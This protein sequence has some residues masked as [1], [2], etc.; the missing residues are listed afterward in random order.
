M[1]KCAECGFLAVRNPTTGGLEEAGGGFREKGSIPIAEPY[2]GRPHPQHEQ[3]PLCF[4]RCHNLGNEI[5]SAFGTGK[6]EVGCVMQVI[7]EERECG[8]SFTEWQLGSTPK[9]HREMMDRQEWRDWQERQRKEDRR[10]RIIESVM[11]AILAGLFTLLG[12][13]IA[14]L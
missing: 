13:F 3:R 6:N 14:N 10:W 8:E 4:V 9:E 2:G 11:F 1:V 7:H 12:A 5:K